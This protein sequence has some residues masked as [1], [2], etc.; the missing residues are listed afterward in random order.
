MTEIMRK[1][2]YEHSKFRKDKVS[3]QVDT[4][5][6][7]AELLKRME[8]L[9][10]PVRKS[11]KKVLTTLAE[12]HGVQ[13]DTYRELAP[14]VLDGMNAGQVLTKL[15]ELE[16]DP[17]SITVLSHELLELA[18]IENSDAIKLY[19]GR[20]SAIAALEK[21]TKEAMDNW[22][23]NERFEKKLHAC[24]KDSPWLIQ[25]HYSR[26]LTSDKP[27]SE[28][29]Q[30]LNAHLKVDSKDFVPPTPEEEQHSESK[31]ERPDLVFLLADGQNPTSVD[32]VELK[33]P[34]IPLR[35]SHLTQLKDYIDSIEKWAHQ[36]L[37]RS[38]KVSGYLIGTLDTQ[39]QARDIKVL[40]KE[41][42][43]A[44]P[45]AN[46]KVLTLHQMLTTARTIHVEALVIQEAE[47]KRLDDLLS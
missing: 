17:K 2:L 30:K 15:I 37:G 1:A 6:T 13:S 34:N 7:S 14:I 24:L 41:I 11:A 27:M 25:P 38:I 26:A 44:G 20:R 4:D 18:R 42:E 32:V 21:L 9:S 33:S 23:S 43:D 36:E 39:S 47:D 31:Q 8:G 12:V 28:L 16:S 10:A 3:K 46:W 45:T 29:L 22:K 40:R 19:R 5:K 35:M